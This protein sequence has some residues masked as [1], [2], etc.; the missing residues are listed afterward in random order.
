M[1]K[2]RL[3][4]GGGSQRPLTRI[5]ASAQPGQIVDSNGRLLQPVEIG[6]MRS[7]QRANFARGKMTALLGS[8]RRLAAKKVERWASK[9][10]RLEIGNTTIL[11]QANAH[12]RVLSC[13]RA[14]TPAVSRTRRNQRVYPSRQTCS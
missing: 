2:S 12:R 13:I 6:E 11:E 8:E 10:Q 3:G 14:R 1:A 7:N 5:A 9:S 4:L